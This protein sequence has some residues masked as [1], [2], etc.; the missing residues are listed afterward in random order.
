MPFPSSR[1]EDDAS[2]PLRKT[3]SVRHMHGFALMLAVSSSIKKHVF[4]L[5][6]AA[7]A[8]LTHLGSYIL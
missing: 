8:R 6:K 7:Q 2:N 5:P 4:E 3:I 1:D